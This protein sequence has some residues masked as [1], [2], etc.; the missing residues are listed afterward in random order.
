MSINELTNNTVTPG[1]AS[2]LKGFRA[3]WNMIPGLNSKQINALSEFRKDI[4]S[5]FEK[6]SIKLNLTYH[7]PIKIKFL[8]E[9]KS[10]L[11]N[12]KKDYTLWRNISNSVTSDILVRNH[13][14]Y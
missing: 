1:L 8:I 10:I 6:N 13:G 4:E 5:T 2:L 7:P 14:N 12:G 9:E 11:P 3:K